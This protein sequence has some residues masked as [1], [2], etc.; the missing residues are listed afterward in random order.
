MLDICCGAGTIGQC[1]LRRIE[2]AKQAGQFNG[3]Y[4]CI[5]VE[6]IDQ[7]VQDARR[8]AE[9]NGFSKDKCRYVSGEAELVFRQ[10]NYYF[11][12]DPADENSI[13]LGVLG[14][15]TGYFKCNFQQLFR[16]TPS[17]TLYKSHHELPKTGKDAQTGLCEL[18]SKIST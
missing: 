16:P 1:L 9:E 6:L 10:L 8:N 4:A 14:L 18:R 12:I 13:Y 7:A 15:Y 17:W 2:R 3:S 11:K 5:G